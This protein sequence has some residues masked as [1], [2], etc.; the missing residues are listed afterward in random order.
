MSRQPLN[1]KEKFDWPYPTLDDVLRNPL[2]S[3]A[4]LTFALF[5]AIFVLLLFLSIFIFPGLLW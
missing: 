1:E 5:A 3:C 2:V 4:A